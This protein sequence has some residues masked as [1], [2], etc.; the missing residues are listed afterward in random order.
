MALDKFLKK[1]KHLFWDIKNP[2]MLSEKAIVECVLNYGEM[3][4]IR[5]L[6]QILT[7]KKIAAIFFSQIKNKRCN[8][9]P[10]I[11][12]YFSLYFKKYA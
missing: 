5:E 6:I 1:R 2:T 4:D 3:D 12:N 11:K 10:K 9:R 8:Y 7:I